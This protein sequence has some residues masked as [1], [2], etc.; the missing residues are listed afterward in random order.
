MRKNNVAERGRNRNIKKALLS[1]G[2]LFVMLAILYF[3]GKASFDVYTK[4]KVAAER[5]MAYMS[6]LAS[7]EERRRSLE[8]ELSRLQTER[9]MEEEIRSRFQVGRPGEEAV[10]IIDEE[11]GEDE[12]SSDETS[13]ENKSWWQ[14]LFGR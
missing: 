1:W 10:I 5:R 3:L 8:V 14:R 9:G 13:E 2:G 12:D 4:S 6:E 7:L 11:V